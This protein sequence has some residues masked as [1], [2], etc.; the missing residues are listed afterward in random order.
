MS[1]RQNRRRRDEQLAA[2]SRRGIDTVEE[3]PDGDWIVRHVTG[4]APGKTYRCPGCDQEVA[5]NIGH[6]VSWPADGPSGAEHRRHWHTPCWR[7]RS[8]RG[9]NIQRSRSAPRYG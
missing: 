6:L 5:G 8:R 7:A 4:S 3:W 1:P 2:P 9:T